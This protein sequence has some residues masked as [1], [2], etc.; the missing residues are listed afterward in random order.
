MIFSL[1]NVIGDWAISRGGVNMM[2]I[3]GIAFAVVGSLVVL[4]MYFS[5]KSA[6]IES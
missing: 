4:V 1:K 6:V 5:H 2:Y 3:V